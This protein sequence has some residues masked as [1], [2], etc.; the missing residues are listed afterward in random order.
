MTDYIA[1]LQQALREAAAREYPVP[2]SSP[3]SPRQLL[4]EDT[5]TQRHRQ[6]L[7][8][9]PLISRRGGR[10]RTA[11]WLAP[12]LALATVVVVAAA[13]LTSGGGASLVTRAY[14][15]MSPTGVIV[16]FV[17]TARSLRPNGATASTS[18]IWIYGDQSHQI[19]NPRSPNRQ[20]LVAHDGRVQT[21]AFNTLSSSRYSPADNRCSAI[22][23][24]EGCVLTQ[25]NS[26]ITA[27]RALYRAGLIHAT[28]H[29]TANGRGVDILTGQS[30]NLRI[31]AL[32]DAHTLLPAKVTM[33]FTLPRT[34]R[35]RVANYVLTITDYQ[36]LPVT[37][38]N[39][40][41]LALPPHPQARLIR[42][43]CQTLY[44]GCAA[45]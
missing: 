35:V 38:S 19:I 23:V 34:G 42:P 28:G 3:Q 16:H 21:L 10:H 27:L 11:R 31:R 36:R 2:A 5:F 4:G 37:T 7:R 26:P 32:V 13:A 14:A 9:N 15:A 22:D 12:A 45:R 30:R 20:D 17:E 33:T 18:E 1:S 24:L 8:R 40:R 39:L 29:A 25:S 44:P 41:Q 6:R 43:P